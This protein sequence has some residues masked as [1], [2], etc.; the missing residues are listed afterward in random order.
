M[1]EDKKQKTCPCCIR[2]PPKEFPGADQI[3]HCPMGSPIKQC[4]SHDHWK[5]KEGWTGNQHWDMYA[6]SLCTSCGMSGPVK[7]HHCHHCK[8]LISKEQREQKM[9]VYQDDSVDPNQYPMFYQPWKYHRKCFLISEL[10]KYEDEDDDDYE[11]RE[12]EEENDK[13]S[14]EASK[15]KQ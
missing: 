12:K 10:E 7:K 2:P 5:S 11:N 13:S 15:Q 4:L 3:V 6:N 8:K 14:S 1:S 9:Y